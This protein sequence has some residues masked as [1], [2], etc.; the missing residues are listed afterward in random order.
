MPGVIDAI[1]NH[2]SN[3]GPGIAWALA[4]YLLLRLH[5]L[6]DRQHAANLKT[7]E[8]L[9]VIKTLLVARLGGSME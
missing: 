7:V 1:V 6:T 5:Q 4:A 8:A 3:G 2:I 9:T